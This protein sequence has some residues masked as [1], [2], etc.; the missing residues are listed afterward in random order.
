MSS[1]PSVL[2]VEL[3]VPTAETEQAFLLLAVHAA[4]KKYRALRHD[5][6]SPP[7]LLCHDEIGLRQSIG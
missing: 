2:Y 6:S 3:L 5:H 1:P 4:L 7:Q